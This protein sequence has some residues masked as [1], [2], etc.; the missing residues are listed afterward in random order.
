MI[1]RL[2]IQVIESISVAAPTEANVLDREAALRLATAVLMIDVARAD[3]VFDESEF[4]RVLQLIETHFKLTPQQA[5]E[6]VNEAGEKADDLIS[7]YEFTEMLHKHLDE[8]EKARI[9]GLLWQIAYAD[10]RLDKYEDAL[11]LKISDLLY[12][13][14]GRVMRLKHDAEQALG[15]LSE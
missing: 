8:E 13:S 11:V 6:L 9:V 4:D 15:G 2:F 14:R 10:G 12:V 7:A 5:A 3:Y 1:K